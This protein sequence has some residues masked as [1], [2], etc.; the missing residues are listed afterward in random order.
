MKKEKKMNPLLSRPIIYLL[1]C[2]YVILD[3]VSRMR[4]VFSKQASKITTI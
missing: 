1:V 2:M 4:G 3:R